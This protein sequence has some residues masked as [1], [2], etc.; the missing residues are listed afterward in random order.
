MSVLDDFQKCHA[1]L[2]IKGLE[3]QVIEEEQILA[4]DFPEL[5][6]IGSIGL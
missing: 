5:F 1:G 2:M 6:V 3:S 4:F